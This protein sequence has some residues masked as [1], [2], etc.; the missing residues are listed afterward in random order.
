MSAPWTLAGGRVLLPDG[1][2]RAADVVVDGATI[3]DV[4]PPGRGRGRGRVVD[5]GGAVVAPGF[6]DCHVHGARG[7]SFMSATAEGLR[8]IARHLAAGGVTACLATTVTAGEAEVLGAIRRLAA[9]RGRIGDAGV[10]LLGIHLEGPFISP[11]RSGVQRAEH[12]R[13][14]S[15]AAVERVL[16]AAGGALRIVTLAPEVP[17]GLAAVRRLTERAVRVAIGHSDATFAQARAALAA[18]ARRMTHLP[19]ALP[20]LHHREPG[21]AVAGLL[22]RDVTIELIADGRH[23]APPMLSLIERAAGPDRIALISDGSDVAGL[24]DGRHRRW[25]GTDV[26]VRDGAV[27]T[28]EGGLAGSGLRLDRAVATM[29]RDAGVPLAAALRMA[30]A[31]PAASLGEPRKGRIAAGADA[32]IVMLDDDLR[33]VRTIA[34]GEVVHDAA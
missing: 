1:E 14:P 19:N 6:V 29:V 30:S 8:E 21:A 9:A 28:V 5:A 23:V 22:E 25:D 16:D 32:D 27:R 31:T 20:P 10:D 3:A 15:R 26:E 2:L 18:G 12:V 13:A 24:P 34:G 7:H 11:K 17:G 33:V 4:A